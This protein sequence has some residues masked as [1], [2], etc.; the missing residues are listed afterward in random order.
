MARRVS[1]FLVALLFLAAAGCDGATKHSAKVVLEGRAPVQVVRGL[2]EL[3]YTENR[4]CAFNALERL[5]LSSTGPLLLLV[6]TLAGIAVAALWWR[7]MNASPA[8]HA[9]FALVAA[10][11]AGNVADR[12]LR[13]YV[14]DFIHVAH[15]PV[16]N[17]ADA[18]I[19][20]G[21]MLIAAARFSDKR[22]A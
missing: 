18:A 14:V 21:A 9:G 7:R 22:R 3:R 5:H 15:W 20:V 17:V 12:A 13:G 11:A 2:V 10:G 6:T 16:F 19:V 1:R 4:D 8:E